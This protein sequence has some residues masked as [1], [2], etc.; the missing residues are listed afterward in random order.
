MAKYCKKIVKRI[1]DLI[2]KDTY[3]IAEICS[4]SDINVDT[5]YDWLKNKPEFSEAITRARERFDQI[6]VKEAKNSLRKLVNGYEVEERKIVYVENQKDAQGKPKIKEQVTTKKHF[7]PNPV[8]VQFVL[9]NKTNG[10]YRNYQTNEL[11]GKDGKDLFA[12]MTDEE[13][14][15]KISEIQRKLN[16]Q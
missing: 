6:I 7:Q 3:T 13:L 15:K 2:E 12:S 11:T 4:M 16:N 1:T 9:T 14:E 5:Y 10:E 8:S